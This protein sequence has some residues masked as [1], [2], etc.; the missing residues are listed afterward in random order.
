MSLELAAEL[1]NADFY[2]TAALAGAVLLWLLVRRAGVA[3]NAAAWVSG[4]AIFAL[5][6]AAV[7]QGWSLPH[8]R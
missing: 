5:R 2:A 7:L 6:T 8:I 4:I 3:A 1:A